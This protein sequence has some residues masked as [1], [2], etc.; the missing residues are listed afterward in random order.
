[1]L[2]ASRRSFLRSVFGGIGV[3]GFHIAQTRDSKLAADI[4]VPDITQIESRIDPDVSLTVSQQAV[5]ITSEASEN[6]VHTVVYSYE[7]GDVLFSTTDRVPESGGVTYT[8]IQARIPSQIPVSVVL[9]GSEG[10][11]LCESDPV[12]VRNNVFI[13]IGGVDES[14]TE[15]VY[16]RKLFSNARVESLPGRYQITFK[17]YSL[18]FEKYR[19]E[20]PITISVSKLAYKQY[21]KGVL[22]SPGDEFARAQSNPHVRQLFEII[23]AHANV[24]TQ[25]EYIEWVTR[26]VQ[27]LPYDYD[28]NTSPLPEYAQTPTEYFVNGTGD[29]EDKAVLLGALLSQPEVS[30]DPIMVFIPGHAALAIPR[31]V[32]DTDQ[33]YNTIIYNDTEYVYLEANHVDSIGRISVYPEP[34]SFSRDIILGLYDDQYTDINPDAF[35]HAPENGFTILKEVNGLDSRLNE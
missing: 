24:D 6:V 11:Y 23:R 31:T 29:C 32:I 1:M 21:S 19:P 35:T 22:R 12:E 2:S 7:S 5:E 13:E 18:R 10:E 33:E 27:T 16:G 30:V 26:F 28:I 9:F 34:V 8:G 4:S 3:T 17:P 15:Y 20:K 25:W 14:T